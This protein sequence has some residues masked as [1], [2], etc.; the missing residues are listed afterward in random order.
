[1]CFAARLA[2]HSHWER[3]LRNKS[4]EL[5]REIRYIVESLLEVSQLA[6]RAK[7]DIDKAEN[8]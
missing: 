6:I 2:W 1:M 3:G 5:R 4:A 7:K 8:G